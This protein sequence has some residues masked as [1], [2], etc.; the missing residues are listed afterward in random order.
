MIRVACAIIRNEDNEILV[1]QRGEKTDHPLKWEFPGGKVEKGEP[2]EE[3]II[4][5]IKEELSIDIILFSR[6]ADIEYDYGKKQIVLIPFICDT[7]EDLPLMTE[8]VAFRWLTPSDLKK[9]DFSEADIIVADKYLKTLESD[10]AGSTDI[11][12]AADPAAEDNEFRAMINST[13]GAKEVEWIA[14]SAVENPVIFKKLFDYSFSD[15]RK[16]AFHSSWALSKVVD[17]YPELIYPYLPRVVEVLDK[18]GNESAQRSFLRIITIADV[19][20]LSSKHHGLLAD[21]C[22]SALRSGFS[23]IAIKAY[24]ME[25]IY[26]LA[27][28]YPELA[29][30]L[31]ATINILQGEGSAGIVARGRIILKKL[32]EM[33]TKPGSNLS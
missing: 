25:I 8:H 10:G 7:L 11:P 21:H 14:V 18:I 5:E 15:D 20:K 33:P 4:R 12:A 6:M 31:A 22:F 1:V 28:I 17:K 30:E 24:S 27:V 23:A 3:C 9:M 2:E 16:L 32:A 13:M 26:K 19:E 29:H